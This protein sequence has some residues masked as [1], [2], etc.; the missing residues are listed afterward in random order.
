MSKT[1]Q[2]TMTLNWIVHIDIEQNCSHLHWT[3][4][5]KLTLKKKT[6]QFHIYIEHKRTVHIDTEQNSSVWHWREQNRTVH[7][8]FEKKTANVDIEQN[9]LHLPWTEQ[10]RT[11]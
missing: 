9:T 1:E 8:D 5:F 2:F 10:N 3:E 6:E 7:I 11:E 4:Q